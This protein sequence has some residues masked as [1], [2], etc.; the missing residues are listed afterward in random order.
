M[1]IPSIDIQGGSTVQ[2]VGGDMTRGPL[3]I[4]VQVHG[5][6]DPL[7]LTVAPGSDDL[8]VVEVRLG[9][10]LSCVGVEPSSYGAP[11]GDPA[12]GE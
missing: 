12:E 4:T 6:V 7:F 11:A 1:I 3:S 10:R 9:T 2:L 8:F 5:F